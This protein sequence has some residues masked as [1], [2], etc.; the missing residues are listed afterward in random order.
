[1]S[2]GGGGLILKVMR[3]NTCML[4]GRCAGIRNRFK[5]VTIKVSVFCTQYTIARQIDKSILVHR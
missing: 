2:Y 3:S 1:M 4:I 5:R